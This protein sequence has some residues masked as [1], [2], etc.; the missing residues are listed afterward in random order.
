MRSTKS[1]NIQTTEFPIIGG[2]QYG[3]YA[4]QT[5]EET[6]N[7]M[8]SDYRGK[9]ALVP[10][11]GYQKTLE[12]LP[13]GEPR[14]IF[15][16]ISFNHMVAVFGKTVL[17][18]SRFLTSGAV[19][20][21]ETSS[22]DVS[23]AENNN[24]EIVI[25]DGSENLYIFNHILSTFT[26]I[27]P[28][29]NAIDLASHNTFIWAAQQN[30]AQV[31]L[32]EANN[33]TSWPTILN[34]FIQS[35]PDIVQ[36][37]LNFNNSVAVIGKVSTTLFY[38]NANDPNFPYRPDTNL[39]LPY[40]T[41][42]RNTV[43][44]L[45]DQNTGP[46][47]MAFLAVNEKSNAF[48]GY[49]RGG[50][51]LSA[52]LDGLDFLLEKLTTPEDSY[53]FL[54]QEDNHVLYQLSF[55][56]DNFSFVY[57]FSSNAYYTVTANDIGKSHPAKRHVHFD[58]KDYFINFND[59]AIF[60]TGTQITTYDGDLI[61]RVRIA[62]PVR[63]PTDEVVLIRQLQIQMEHGENQDGGIVDLALSKD[64]GVTYG[65]Y[66]AKPMSPKGQR[67]QMIKY[68]NLGYSNDFRMQFR[69][70]SRGRFVITDA[71]MMSLS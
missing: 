24:G 52:S 63:Q 4:K 53:G 26:T 38:P 31:R 67:Q 21:L 47:L 2:S 19:G 23:I 69:F 1:Y 50:E 62:P 45:S 25:A 44:T 17:I 16:S 49:S 71:S 9:Q 10:Y 8:L 29:F 28:G 57:D 5:T 37:V 70:H 40:G 48:I 58:Q 65:S 35:K 15:D 27:Q 68:W 18:I 3:R 12:F 14:E 55:P 43:D 66:V 51:M 7:M 30:S 39:V 32:S 36:S 13:Y 54:F 42:S 20:E 61:P 41:V 46:K 22:G 11:L 34:A 33:A 60:E 6:V 56:S 64:G 59:A